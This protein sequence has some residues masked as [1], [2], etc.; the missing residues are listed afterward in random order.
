MDQEQ[1]QET[2]VVVGGGLAAA[3]AVE[4]L[5][6]RGY[7]GRLVLIG[8][9]EHRPYE[10]PPLSKGYLGG[11]TEREKV[12]AHPENWYEEHDVELRLGRRVVAIDRG[13]RQLRLADGTRVGYTKLLLATGASPRRLPLLGANADQ[14]VQLRTLD[15]SDQLKDLFGRIQRLAVVG[16]GWIGLEAAAAARTAGVEV[17]VVE[18]ASAPLI[19][20]LG[21]EMGAVFADLH[22]RHGVDLRL[23]EQIAEITTEGGYATGLRLR[24][25]EVL[26]A[27]A[28]LVGVGAA[29]NDQLAKDA[30]LEAEDGV[31]VDASLR[32]SDPAIFAA[33]D[34]ARALHPRYG[35]RIRVEHW[36]NAL[37]QPAVAAA[38]MLG[39]Q[40]EYSRLPYF[41]SDQYDL[42]MEFVGL[43]EPGGY[44]SV[45]TRGD[46]AGGEFIAFWLSG[47]RVVAGM[48]VNVWDVVDPIRALIEGGQVVDQ[49]RLTDP[50]VPLDSVTGG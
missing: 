18:Q 5:R 33:G 49:A 38:G 4:A 1:Q 48:N 14:V 34:V 15:D 30:D 43:V 27:D 35:R 31:L 50:A 37:N 40:A 42:G 24:G 10:R 29:P 19:G 16:A 3:K 13:H 23:D 12:F 26:A 20:A 39:E 17:T 2:F 47:G 25:G 22:R 41:F 45:V 28:I 44:D 6:E 36:A 9:E 8:E 46:P 21:P 7:S 32:S 11:K